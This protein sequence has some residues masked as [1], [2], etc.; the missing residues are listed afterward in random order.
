M[1]VD[2]GCDLAAL[3][4]LAEEAAALQGAQPGGR[5]RQALAARRRLETT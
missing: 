3:A 4:G 5:V 1:G 2:T